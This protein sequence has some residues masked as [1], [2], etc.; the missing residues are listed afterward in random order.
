MKGFTVYPKIA[1]RNL[2]VRLATTLPQ[3][4]HH[5]SDQMRVVP[6]PPP[7]PVP[8]AP[9]PLLLCSSA[10][11]LAGMSLAALLASSLTPSDVT[12]LFPA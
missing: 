10:I 1:A 11:W 4:S 9:R 12:M 3:A 7:E 5:V 8:G 2:Q 6:C